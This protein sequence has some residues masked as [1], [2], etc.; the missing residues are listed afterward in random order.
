MKKPTNLVAY[1]G[2]EVIVL[3]PKR[4]RIVPCDVNVP[5]IVRLSLQPFGQGGPHHA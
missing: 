4:V 2:K 5:G 3:N 1:E